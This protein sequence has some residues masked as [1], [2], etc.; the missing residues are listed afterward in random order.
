M[1]SRSRSVAIGEQAP[2]LH[3]HQDR[4]VLVHPAEPAREWGA[5]P[6]TRPEGDHRIGRQRE[7]A[8]AARATVDGDAAGREPLLEAPARGL[9]VERAQPLREGHSPRRT[10]S[11]RR[12]RR[13]RVPRMPTSSASPVAASTPTARVPGAHC[14]GTSKA[15]RSTAQAR[16]AARA[17]P[18]RPPAA[19]EQRVL[20]RE[21]AG[22][23]AA[24]GPERLQDHRL[25]EAL[26]ARDGERPGH[27]DQARPTLKAATSPMDWTA[28]DQSDY[29]KQTFSTRS[30][31]RMAF[32][33]CGGN[34][35]RR[36]SS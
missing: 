13:R 9:R 16:A 32:P 23:E 22:D 15:Q 6:G 8:V 7:A 30:R 26:L 10:P 20:D 21:H 5:R 18:A 33:I 19:P 31:R 35:T 28:E 11:G 1:R 17:L 12:A 27:D 14:H 34:T 24:G 25:V 4:V 2:G 36:C 3:H 29:L